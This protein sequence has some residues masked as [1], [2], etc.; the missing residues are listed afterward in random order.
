MTA[1]IKDENEITRTKQV[2]ATKRILWGLGG[3]TDCMIANG[4]NGLIDQIYTIALALNPKWVGI[5]RSVPRFLDF[6]TDPLIGH[7]S[8]NTRSRWGRRK[9]WMLAGVAVAA[10][11]AVVMWYP[12]LALGPVAVNAF[13]VVMLSLLFT[14]GYALF[15]IPYTAMGYEMSTD[16]DERTHIY[17]YRILAFTAVGFVTPWLAR[18]CLE[19]EG[20]KSEVL[21]GL[22]G[23]HWVS[24]GVAAIIVLCGLMPI[25][26]CKDV[27]HGKAENKVSFFAAVGYT[28][29]NRAFWPILLS[30]F[31]MR[32]GMCIT[33]IFFYYLFI[34]RIGGNMK[35][36]ATEWGWFVT[37]ITIA[38]LV[39]TPLVASLSQR[40]GKKLTV[41]ILMATSAAAYASVWWT[42]QPEWSPMKL[43][44]LT[45]VGI[46]VFCN[47]M[48]MI[49]NSMLA[50]VCDVDELNSGHRREAFYGAVFVTCDKIA[51]AVTLFMQGFLLEASGFNAKLDVQTT[52]TV[53]TWMRWL[54]MT[55][56]TGLILGMF[57]IL[58]YPLTKARLREVQR[59]LLARYQAQ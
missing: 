8:D 32:F 1:D 13:I 53:D 29:R 41:V 9:P 38:T 52:E 57:C 23:I 44:L 24:L 26:F 35:G 10:I 30:N 14:V 15:T 58:A 56:P 7:L 6:V 47:T 36:G 19:L 42:F 46:G 37:A 17:K 50:D 28:A 31:F 40:L 33:G 25:L 12:P 34:Y 27:Y 54:L 4:L 49:I 45:G 18:L 21:K 20:E 39:G 22:Q 16:S 2:P 5:A 59:Q 43:Y 55:Q 51:M 3:I 11:T 48:P